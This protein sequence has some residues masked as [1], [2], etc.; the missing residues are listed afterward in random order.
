MLKKL[1]ATTSAGSDITNHIFIIRQINKKN[2]EH[3]TKNFTYCYNKRNMGLHE[4]IRLPSKTYKFV[5]S[6]NESEIL[7]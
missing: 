1:L 7:G 5:K 4:R 2:W 6:N 3:S